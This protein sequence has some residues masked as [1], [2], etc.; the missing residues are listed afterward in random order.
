MPSSDFRVTTNSVARRSLEN[1]QTTLGRLADK[2]DELS[3]MKKLRRPSDSPVDTVSAMRLR[4]D[5]GRHEQISRNIDDAMSWLGIADNTLTPPVDQLQ[6]VR[7]LAI[8]ARNAPTDSNA[9]QG[10]AAEVD[11]IRES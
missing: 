1:L 7:D 11:K 2:Q 8:Q 10:I 4:A 3:S 5:L 6:R 9:R